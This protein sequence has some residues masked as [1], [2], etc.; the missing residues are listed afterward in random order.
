MSVLFSYSVILY[1]DTWP[2]KIFMICLFKS[3]NNKPFLPI[4]TQVFALEANGD[5]AFKLVCVYVCCIKPHRV[6]WQLPFV[7]I[8]PSTAPP[9]PSHILCLY[10]CKRENY[11]FL[12]IGECCFGGNSSMLSIGWMYFFVYIT[13]EF[14]FRCFMIFLAVYMSF[15]YVHSLRTHAS[16]KTSFFYRGYRIKKWQYTKATR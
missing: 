12:F 11:N 4:K 1:R 13:I 10:S 9:F 8:F 7:S 6:R 3:N 15:Y 14:T 5:V 16:I 2:R